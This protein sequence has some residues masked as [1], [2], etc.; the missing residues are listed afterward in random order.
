ML[1]A[2]FLSVRSSVPLIV[3]IKRQLASTIPPFGPL[4]RTF[5]G[6]STY[7]EVSPQLTICSFTASDPFALSFAP[8][9]GASF[10]YFSISNRNLLVSAST[11]SYDICLGCPKDNK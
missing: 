6:S 1:I 11:F 3:N 10:S 4:T 5:P 9:C 2:T 7:S 8:P